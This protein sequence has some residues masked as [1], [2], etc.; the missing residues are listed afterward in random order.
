MSANKTV[1]DQGKVS[2]TG[3]SFFSIKAVVLTA[4]TVL[5]CLALINVD[6]SGWNTYSS[7]YDVRI[8]FYKRKLDSL[9][10]IKSWHDRM[11]MRHVANVEIP[12]YAV[13]HMQPGD[14]LLLPPMGYGNKYMKSNAVWTDPRIFTYMI[15]FQPI[16]A[17]SNIERR[18]SANTFIVL[19]KNQIWI[20]RRGGTTNIDSLLK[21]YELS[22]D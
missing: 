10:R 14:T 18:S 19:D 1:K 9:T 7:S 21:V 5:F 22:N 12:K 20:A 16:V 8:G 6:L 15:G 17:Y 2:T 4:V 3:S 13:S 11:F